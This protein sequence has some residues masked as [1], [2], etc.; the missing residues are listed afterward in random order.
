MVRQGGMNDHVIR[1]LFELHLDDYSYRVLG[2]LEASPQTN[3][4]RDSKS[5]E[6]TE[7]QDCHFPRLAPQ[8]I[9]IVILQ[10]NLDSAS[11]IVFRISYA[12]VVL[13]TP[14]LLYSS[15]L[16]TRPKCCK[17]GLL[18]ESIITGPKAAESGNSLSN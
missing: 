17:A 16:H 2:D 1:D 13:S 8:P 5:P 7:L 14:T 6:A 4:S 3:G 10:K 12:L 15:N 11:R 18:G 9:T